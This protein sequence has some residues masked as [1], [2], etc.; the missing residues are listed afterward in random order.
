[1]DARHVGEN[2][3]PGAK[4]PI[5]PAHICPC[6]PCDFGDLAACGRS[7]TGNGSK[8]LVYCVCFGVL[9]FPSSLLHGAGDTL[10][11]EGERAGSA[12]VLRRTEEDGEHAGSASDFLMKMASS[13]LRSSRLDLERVLPFFLTAVGGVAVPHIPARV[14]PSSVCILEI[15]NRSCQIIFTA[16]QRSKNLLSKPF[17]CLILSF[18]SRTIPCCPALREP[19]LNLLEKC[20]VFR[21]GVR[22]YGVLASRSRCISLKDACSLSPRERGCCIAIQGT[23]PATSTSPTSPG[24]APVSVVCEHHVHLG[25]RWTRSTSPSMH[26]ANS[27]GGRKSGSFS[28]KLDSLSAAPQ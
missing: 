6:I 2:I 21:T 8:N 1:M 5:L 26:S 24:R 18:I 22:S 11:G 13:Y 7:E 4:S 12:S 17:F 25:P 9:R 20:P 10:R 14:S 16:L 23:C 19:L 27:C 28:W 15:C 3:L